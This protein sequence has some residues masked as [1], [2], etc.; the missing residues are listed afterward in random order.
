VGHPAKT[1]IGCSF[2]LEVVPVK[3][4]TYDKFDIVHSSGKCC[5]FG[6]SFLSPAAKS[7]AKHSNSNETILKRPHCSGNKATPM[8]L[9]SKKKYKFDT[10]HIYK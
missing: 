2:A 10:A 9:R 6:R 3:R 4:L 5:I 8:R 1:P 7:R